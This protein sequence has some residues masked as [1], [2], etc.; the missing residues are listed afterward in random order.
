MGIFF[1][2]GAAETKKLTSQKKKK[3]KKNDAKKVQYFGKQ[4]FFDTILVWWFTQDRHIWRFQLPDFSQKGNQNIVMKPAFLKQV[5][6]MP[7]WIMMYVKTKRLA[8]HAAVDLRKERKKEN[9]FACRKLPVSRIK[10]Q[11]LW[12]E[13]FITHICACVSV[14]LCMSDVWQ[15]KN[16]TALRVR[17]LCSLKQQRFHALHVQASCFMLNEF[18]SYQLNS[19]RPQVSSNIKKQTTEVNKPHQDGW[20]PPEWLKF[21]ALIEPQT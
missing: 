8:T 4:N 6:F 1:L 20:Y 7:W 14:S 19:I 12:E 21:A 13:A 18:I 16:T 11:P 10:H 9:R 5:Q 17:F 3:N 15:K 2:F